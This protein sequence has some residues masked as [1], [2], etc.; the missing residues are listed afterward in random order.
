MRYWIELGGFAK[1]L[2]LL[3]ENMS[4]K[5][6]SK[7]V[8]DTAKKTTADTIKTIS[9]TAIQKNSRSNS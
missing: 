7:I 8:P 3:P 5:Y 4:D 1:N 9:K 6:S 2:E